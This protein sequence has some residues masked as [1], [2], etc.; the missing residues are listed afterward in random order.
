[1]FFQ[2]ATHS[3]PLVLGDLNLSFPAVHVSDG[4]HLLLVIVL[5]STVFKG[6]NSTILAQTFFCRIGVYI[7]P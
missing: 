2:C 1:M 6:L 4:T 5:N 7:N 3:E